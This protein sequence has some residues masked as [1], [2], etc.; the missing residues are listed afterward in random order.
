[1]L[2]IV[3]SADVI[4]TTVGAFATVTG[5]D[6]GTPSTVAV[7]VVLPL[8]TATRRMV[9]RTTVTGPTAGTPPPVGRKATIAGLELVQVTLA[10]TI[11]PPASLRGA[12]LSRVVAL[13]PFSVA[14]PGVMAT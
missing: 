8:A 5:I 4:W 12:A 7:I 3:V 9:S 13:R 14:E 6:V 1:M 2:A 10:P 11:A